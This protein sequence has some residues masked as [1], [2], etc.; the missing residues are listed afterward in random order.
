MFLSYNFVVFYF[1]LVMEITVVVTIIGF[2]VQ[3]IITVLSIGHYTGKFETKLAEH[4]SAI[5]EIGRFQMKDYDDLQKHKDQHN[6]LQQK[7]AVNEASI[8]SSLNGL[9]KEMKETKEALKDFTKEMKEWMKEVH[10][11]SNR[12]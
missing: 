6:S 1:C 10:A 2:V 7:V 11:S 3:M 12:K 5:K 8:N 9:E 4:D